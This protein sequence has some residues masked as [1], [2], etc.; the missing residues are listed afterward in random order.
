M[1]HTRNNM[2]R[3][4][5]IIMIGPCKVA[6]FRNRILRNGEE[7]LVPKVK[8]EVRYKDKRTG[9]W[10]GTPCM[11]VP[12]IPKAILALQKAYEWL[13]STKH[14]GVLPSRTPSLSLSAMQPVNSDLSASDR[15]PLRNVYKP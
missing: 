8:F 2:P 6:I 3:P 1:G 10:K 5:K 9:K 15:P 13:V 12:E 7:I 11:T 14:D 4:D